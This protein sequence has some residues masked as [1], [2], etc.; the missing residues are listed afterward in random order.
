MRAAE[1]ARFNTTRGGTWVPDDVGQANDHILVGEPPSRCD[2]QVCICIDRANVPQLNIPNLVLY[3]GDNRDYCEIIH[4]T[5]PVREVTVKSFSLSVHIR[6]PGFQ[7]LSLVDPSTASSLSSPSLLDAPCN[8]PDQF[9]IYNA[10]YFPS[11]LLAI[12]VMLAH[13]IVTRGRPRL[14]PLTFVPPHVGSEAW[15]PTTASPRTPSF[16]AGD[17]TPAFL[18]TPSVSALR[19]SP[20]I[21]R[22]ASPILRASSPCFL[23]TSSPGVF[24]ASTPRSRPATPSSSVFSLPLDSDMDGA[25]IGKDRGADADGKNDSEGER[26]TYAAQYHYDDEEWGVVDER[27]GM[28]VGIGSDHEHE[29]EH[30]YG[31]GAG[32]GYFDARPSPAEKTKSLSGE[33]ATEKLSGKPGYVQHVPPWTWTFVLFG[34]RRRVT[35]SAQSV[36]DALELL[37]GSGSESAGRMTNGRRRGVLRDTAADVVRVVCPA[38]V[39]WVLMMAYV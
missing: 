10:L 34:R 7:L 23:R 19:T 14:S 8:L 27:E 11:F 5:V 1:R 2:F 13:H 31:S 17:R 18:R 32:E 16:I 30:V 21:L 35:L 36:V 37:W 9:A 6:R 28:G 38:V 24:R 22:T 26:N 39:V 12:L 29:Y 33:F 15:S 4:S 25:Y 3:S 20:N